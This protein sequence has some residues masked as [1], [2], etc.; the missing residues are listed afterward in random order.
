MVFCNRFY[1]YFYIFQWY[2]HNPYFNRWFS[3][4]NSI[5]FYKQSYNI[6]TILILIDGFLQYNVK[7]EYFKSRG[8]TI[9]IL[10]DGFLQCLTYQEETLLKKVTILILIDGFLQYMGDNCGYAVKMC[11]NPY[12]NRWFSAI[13]V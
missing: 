4:I 1:Y 10:I 13:S 9:L 11:H 7:V 12:F 5:I 2:S 3:A 6:V 8:V